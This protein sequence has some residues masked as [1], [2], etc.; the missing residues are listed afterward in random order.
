MLDSD[1]FFIGFV[2]I[3]LAAALLFPGGPGTPRRL[4]LSA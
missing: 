1:L 4:R 2:L 3:L